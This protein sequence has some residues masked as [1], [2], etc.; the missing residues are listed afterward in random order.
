MEMYLKSPIRLH[1]Q[2]RKNFTGFTVVH[3]CK[4]KHFAVSDRSEL[5]ARSKV[6][7]AKVTVLYPVA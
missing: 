6:H 4:G 1:S 3:L 5:A 7:L 2:H